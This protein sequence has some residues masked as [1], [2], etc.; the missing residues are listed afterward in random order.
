MP[1]FSRTIEIAVPIEKLFE[2]HI[3]PAN[4]IHIAPESSKT[5]LVSSS[6]ETLR[7]GTRVVVRSHQAGMPIK[8]DAEVIELDA[9]RLLRDRQVSGPFGRWVHTHRFESTA[10]G[11][12]LTDDVD[13]ALP[14][15]LLGG[16]VMGNTV[17]RELEQ[18]FTFRQE[19]TKEMLE[20]GDVR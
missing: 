14:M 16:F 11:S 12:R 15:G 5:E 1:R 13:Y 6:D 18:M 2:F 10:T 8:M 3:N 7:V 19:R 20:R 17:A 9:P 4:L